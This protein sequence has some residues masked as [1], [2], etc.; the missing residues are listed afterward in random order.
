MQ[1]SNTVVAI[2]VLVAG[3]TIAGA[4]LLSRPK[5]P[6]PPKPDPFQEV[7]AAVAAKMVDPESA[8]FQALSEKVTGIV[9]C[10]AVNAKNRMG[11]Y[12]GF[13]KFYAT[14]SVSGDWVIALDV[15]IAEHMCK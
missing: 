11:G 14:K 12:V 10:G 4:I 1:R 7:K 15:Q 6:E 3:C 2:A 8:R 13:R 5:P 9:Y